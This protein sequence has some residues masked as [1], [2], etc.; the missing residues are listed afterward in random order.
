M[1]VVEGEGKVEERDGEKVRGRGG[2]EGRGDGVQ[3]DMG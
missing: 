1:R 2:K 3:G